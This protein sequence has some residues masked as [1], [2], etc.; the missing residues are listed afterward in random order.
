MYERLIENWLTNVNELGYQIPFR[1]VLLTLGFRILY[2][3]SHGPGEH[4]KDIVARDGSGKLWAFQ[5]KGGRIKLQEWRR[6]RDE[7]RELVELPV[8]FPGISR[9]EPFQPVLVTNG[10]LT[11]DARDNIHAYAGKWSRSGSA[12]LDV[13]SGRKLLAMFVE[14]H[15]SFLP[16]HVE[17]FR[18]LAELYGFDPSDRIPRRKLLRLLTEIVRSESVGK[19]AQ[20][21]K[22]ALESMVLS[23]SYLVGQYESVENYVSAVEGWTIVAAAV[24]YMVQRDGISPQA[25][26]PSLSLVRHAYEGNLFRLSEEAK[27]APNWVQGTLILAEPGIFPARVGLML[28]WLA[29][30]VLDGGRPLD[31]RTREVVGSVLLRELPHFRMVG[32]VDFPRLVAVILL[33][34]MLGH[35]EVARRLLL[36]WVSGLVGANSGKTPA[37]VPSPYWDQERV[38]RRQHGMI[39]TYRDE[40]FG[41]DSYTLLQSLDMA[42]RRGFREEVASTWPQASRI[43]FNDFVPDEEHWFRWRAEKGNLNVIHWPQPVSWAEWRSE[44]RTLGAEQLPSA[45]SE[46]AEWALPFALGI[47][48][49]MNRALSALID[50]RYSTLSA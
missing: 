25:Y 6:M 4:G 7:V 47:P 43:T 9:T 41:R 17:D 3:S 44:Q 34:E 30:A 1:E 12:R 18:L 35:D 29:A 50:K 36:D 38:L 10:D 37:G 26:E 13:W 42:V 46:H 22:R 14:A 33:A 23:G 2:V 16:G 31:E 48:H 27:N 32:E 21:R 24:L 45:L 5:L 20:Q 19:T 15:G 11:T 40:A 8:Q 49:R 28:G 39:P